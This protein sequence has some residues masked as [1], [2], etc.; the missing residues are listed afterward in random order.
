VIYNLTD[1]DLA[2]MRRLM[3]SGCATPEEIQRAECYARTAARALG[4]RDFL[5]R[6]LE[7]W[8]EAFASYSGK[9]DTILS[10]SYRE[11]EAREILLD[12]VGALR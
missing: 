4:E 6:S 1:A 10:S 3:L 11:I 5:E 12:P 8:K 2:E 7:G 9:V